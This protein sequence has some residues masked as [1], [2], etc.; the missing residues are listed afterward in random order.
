[1]V[2]VMDH[3]LVTNGWEYLKTKSCNVNVETRVMDM[4][5]RGF[6][7]LTPY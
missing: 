1:M 5:Q 2:S 3:V 4:E 7:C 6:Q